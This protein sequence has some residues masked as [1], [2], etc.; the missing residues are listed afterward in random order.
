LPFDEFPQIP[1]LDLGRERGGKGREGNVK[2]RGEGRE[3]KGMKLMGRAERV[4]KKRVNCLLPSRCVDAGFG[5]EDEEDVDDEDETVSG[6]NFDPALAGREA[7][8]V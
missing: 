5:A 6:L 7:V 3:N 1:K 4:C 2:A 8:S